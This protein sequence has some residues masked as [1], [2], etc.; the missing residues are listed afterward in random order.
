[1]GKKFLAKYK[2]EK[3]NN[4][5]PD[6]RCCG[7]VFYTWE[8]LEKHIAVSHPEE[9]KALKPHFEGL[10][11]K[12]DIAAQKEKEQKRLQRPPKIIEDIVDVRFVCPR[13]H[14]YRSNG[15]VVRYP[16]G[17]IER[18][19]TRCEARMRLGRKNIVQ[20]MISVPFETSRSKH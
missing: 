17:K 11:H 15:Y 3:T 5:Q 1:M 13:C 14:Q 8:D 4:L 18:I 12:K 20:K 19:C 6:Y 7:K 16:S 10:R 2:N 9:Y